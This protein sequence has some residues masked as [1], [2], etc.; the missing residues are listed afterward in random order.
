LNLKRFFL[1]SFV[2]HALVIAALIFLVHPVKEKKPGGEFYTSLVSPEELLPR[3]PATLP[4]PRVRSMPG[5]RSVP[6]RPSSRAGH[7]P[8][9]PSA[10]A[11]P[12]VT[13][14]APSKGAGENVLPERGVTSPQPPSV[15][16]R[17]ESGAGSENTGEGQRQARPAPSL[18]ERLFDRDI[19]ANLAKRALEKEEEK[20]KKD[21]SFTFDASE[22]RFLLYNKRLKERIES[23]WV[24]PPYEAE[25]GIYG[26]LMIRFTIK[27]NGQLGSVE[28]LRTSGH[29]SLDDAA[30]KALR[31]GAPYWPLPDDWGMEAYTIEGH[32]I[33]T[34]YGYFIR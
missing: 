14:P 32:F 9:R 12:G 2:V 25:H 31:D 5:R 16:S 20:E 27:K 13:T 3:R 28:L 19:V 34:I 18:R 7:A 10:P 22:Y 8:P 6:S 23:I 33:Y 4:P 1:Y 21:K 30:I 11:L 24:Y 29:K 26:D 15:A 17:P